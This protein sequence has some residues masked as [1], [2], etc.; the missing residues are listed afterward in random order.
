VCPR[1]QETAAQ[2]AATAAEL[3]RAL[4]GGNGR[5]SG[6]VAAG[7]ARERP[8]DALPAALSNA[9]DA[10]LA[11]AAKLERLHGR[12]QD[13]KDAHLARLAAARTRPFCTI[14]TYAEWIDCSWISQ[15][16]MF[17]TAEW[18]GQF[19]VC[20]AYHGIFCRKVLEWLSC[21]LP[22]TGRGRQ[23]PLCGGGGEGTPAEHGR[24][25]ALRVAVARAAAC[26]EPRSLLESNSEL[27]LP[28]AAL[29]AG[30]LHAGLS[31]PCMR[32][33]PPRR[34]AAQCLFWRWARRHQ[35]PRRQ[36]HSQ[37]EASLAARLRSL[38]PPL[39][40]SA[41]RSLPRRL[42]ASL[43]HPPQAYLGLL[44]LHQLP[45]CARRVCARAGPGS[46]PPMLL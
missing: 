26:R 12:V 15:I 6:G 18:G 3:E 16:R 29:L 45:W 44:P 23:R 21:M 10:L 36:L 46:E 34:Q 28:L 35:P 1:M 43:G 27:Y 19:Y 8:L 32:R 25:A 24:Q 17:R 41:R 31:S 2:Y 22:C 13:A 40:S 7:G 20:G 38:L 5:V 33:R 11:V 39:A 37:A 42:A 14:C 4:P 9:H 30:S